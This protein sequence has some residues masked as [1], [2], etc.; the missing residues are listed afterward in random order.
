[1]DVKLTASCNTIIRTN[2]DWHREHPGDTRHY[3]GCYCKEERFEEAKP[4]RPPRHEIIVRQPC[5]FHLDHPGVAYELCT[6]SVMVAD[7]VTGKS[8]IIPVNKGFLTKKI[9]AAEFK[10][11]RKAMEAERL[12]KMGIAPEPINKPKQIKVVPAVASAGT[13]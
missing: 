8:Q 3:W 7:G 13:R 4:N 2:C 5:G 6:C 1:M 10:R 11:R 12:K 9:D